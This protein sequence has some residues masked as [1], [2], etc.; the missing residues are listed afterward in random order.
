MSNYRAPDGTAIDRDEWSL[1][2]AKRAEDMSDE[3]W[4]R[5]RTAVGESRVSTVWLGLEHV[6][7]HWETMIF[8]G[9]H[10]EDCWRWATR[11]EA[12]AGHDRIVQALKEDRDPNPSQSGGSGRMGGSRRSPA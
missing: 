6:G 5:R 2:F 3:S 12:L 8:G 11:E 9:E 1:L 10:D 7:G 4:W